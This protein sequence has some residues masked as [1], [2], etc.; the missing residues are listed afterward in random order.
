M[1]EKPM[2][3]D[4]DATSR[5]LNTANSQAVASRATVLAFLFFLVGCLFWLDCLFVLFVFFLCVW[6][7]FCSGLGLVRKG[8]ATQRENEV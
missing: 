1:Q 3:E 7:F 4:E 6:G 2:V 5:R 8:L